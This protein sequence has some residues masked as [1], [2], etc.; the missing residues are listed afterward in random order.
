MPELRDRES[1]NTFPDLLHPGPGDQ[2]FHFSKILMRIINPR[3]SFQRR[4][5]IAGKDGIQVNRTNT[6]HPLEEQEKKQPGIILGVEQTAFIEKTPQ[7]FL[8]E[9]F[10]LQREGTAQLSTHEH[11]LI[12]TNRQGIADTVH[13]LVISQVIGNSK[14]DFLHLVTK[15][16]KITESGMI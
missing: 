6:I 7:S 9:I 3:N 2:F 12:T 15:A 11:H 1:F 13:S 16:S 5:K 14:N 8:P 4:N 10:C